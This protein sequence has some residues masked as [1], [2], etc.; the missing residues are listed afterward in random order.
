MHQGQ[1]LLC[2][3]HNSA[4]L[5]KQSTGLRTTAVTSLMRLMLIILL[6]HKTS[7]I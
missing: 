3:I 2:K 4:L 5:G 7:L 1:P 6:A